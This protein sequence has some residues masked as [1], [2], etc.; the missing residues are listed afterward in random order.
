[1]FTLLGSPGR[2]KRPRSPGRD[3]RPRS[4]GRDKRT[5]SHTISSFLRLDR[6]LFGN[7]SFINPETP[8]SPV[9][10]PQPR[11]P[12]E[13]PKNLYLGDKSTSYRINKFTGGNTKCRILGQ[14]RSLRTDNG[15]AIKA[16]GPYSVEFIRF[17]LE[18]VQVV[19]P[20]GTQSCSPYSSPPRARREY[21]A[22]GLTNQRQV[23]SML[24][25]HGL[26]TTIVSDEDIKKKWRLDFEVQALNTLKKNRC[27]VFSVEHPHLAGHWLV[28][29]RDYNDKMTD[30]EYAC[31]YDSYTGNVWK[32]PW[33]LLN[34]WFN[35]KDPN[36]EYTAESVVTVA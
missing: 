29:L 11:R 27:F 14:H 28:M 36:D 18:N 31:V 21:H 6:C 1:M 26:N 23:A 13:K 10:R 32:L 20:C 33:S 24:K 5:R 2:D 35:R 4:P 12:R 22:S 9:H 30:E 3:K 16:C 8:G 19:S 7:G 34:S 25:E 15:K 17:H